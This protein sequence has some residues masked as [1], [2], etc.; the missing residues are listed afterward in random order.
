M[1]IRSIYR[2]SSIKTKLVVSIILVSTVISYVMYEMTHSSLHTS[3]SRVENDYIYERLH[4]IRAIISEKPDYLAIIKQDI[5]WE[6]ENIRF[7][8]YYLRFIDESGRVLIETPGMGETIPVQWIP[9]PP[10]TMDGALHDVVRAHN[11]RYFLLKADSVTPT[12][13]AVKKL[14]VQIALDVTSGV[15]IDEANHG[16]LLAVVMMRAIFFAGVIILIVQRMFRPLE[17]MVA[18]SEH[19]S[20]SRISERTRPENWPKEVKRLAISFNT[21]LDR[22]EE[23]LTRL[24]HCASNMAHEMRTP[25]NNFMGEA[26][27]TLMQERSPDE[28]KKVLESGIEECTRLSQLID[29]L[30]FLARAENPADSI[31]RTLFNPIEDIRDICSFYEPM[32]EEKGAHLTWHGQGLLY[33]DRLLFRRV[34]TN[35]LTNALRYSPPGV[36]VDIA[37][38]EADDRYME[39]VVT[40]TGY[41]MT[42]EDL[43]RVFDRFYRTEA[44]RLK[45][46]EGSG[47]GLSLVRAIMD[48]H[49]GSVTIASRPDEGTTVTLLFPPDHSTPQRS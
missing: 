22:L 12:H 35:L 25:I 13:G 34:I 36:K 45:N 39:I 14:T 7:P 6:G 46:P 24:S 15:T 9:P 19:V 31:D 18:F 23:A 43:N 20:I 10:T 38:R 28:Y 30:L 3:L 5:E 11:G 32:T 21:M 42:A 29:S 47:L 44:S 40:D 49:G 26:E 37:V 48:L 27:I 33:G 41:G 4:M 8:N 1:G 16:K 2:S 17:E